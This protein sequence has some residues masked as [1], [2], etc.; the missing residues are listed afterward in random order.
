MI[1]LKKHYNSIVSH[2][3]ILR[4]NFLNVMQKPSL[5]KISF[6]MGLGSKLISDKKDLVKG[7]LSLEL[8]SQQKAVVTR[9]KTSLDK[10]KIKKGMILGSKVNL[11]KNKM[12]LFLD[13]LNNDILPN[14][15][16]FATFTKN[17]NKSLTKN[18]QNSCY[19]VKDSF[20]IHLGIQDYFSF[21][22]I[23]YDKFDKILGLNLS[24]I[25]KNGG[26]SKRSNLSKP[27]YL[28]FKP[29]N[30]NLSRTKTS[31]NSKASL[32]TLLS[33]FQIPISQN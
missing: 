7:L 33:S 4:D 9:S 12:Y 31:P 24:F 2:D 19:F 23:P 22:Q 20:A 29:L 25:F 1:R 13:S 11:R 21:K 8:I 5:N 10:F 16:E 30:S 15:E 3:L 26:V 18:K 32:N 27:K 28:T 6:N 14:L 17:Y